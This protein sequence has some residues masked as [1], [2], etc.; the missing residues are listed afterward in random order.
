MGYYR[1]AMGVVI[2]YDITDHVS[3]EH[4]EYWVQQLEQHGDG[5]IHRILVG[6]KSDLG[7]CRKVAR[8][9]GAALASKFNMAFFETSAKSGDGVDD[10]FLQIADQVVAQRYA[11][12]Q[13]GV[14]LRNSSGSGKA[15]KKCCK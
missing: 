14:E 2:T 5:S 8:Q 11:G 1:A 15:N 13:K 4:V 6:N 9:D 12:A 10:A 7:E 3:F